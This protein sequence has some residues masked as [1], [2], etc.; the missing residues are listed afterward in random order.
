MG[1]QHH[2]LQAEDPLAAWLDSYRRGLREALDASARDGFHLIHANTVNSELD[3]A[4][5]SG[6]ARRHLA[7]HLGT[8]GLR[9]DGVAADF[10]GLGLADPERAEERLAHLRRTLELCADLHVPRAIVAIGGFGDERIAGL[11]RQLLTETAELADRYGVEIAIRDPAGGSGELDAHL[12]QLGSPHLGAAI[13]SAGLSAERAEASGAAGG[14]PTQIGAV[15][16]RDARRA[17]TQLEE[18]EYGAGQVDFSRLFGELAGQDYHGPFIVRRD[19]A[20][21]PVDALRRGREYLL[22]LLAGRAPR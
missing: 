6:T 17:G 22:A 8:I 16:L 18:V 2:T 19:A 3:P 20:G 15:L 9:L 5:F 12:R 21:L 13:D 14:L 10:G 4:S 11:A 7:R 1:R